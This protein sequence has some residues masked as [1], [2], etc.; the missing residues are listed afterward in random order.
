M[1]INIVRQKQEYT[2]SPEAL[3]QAQRIGI[4]GNRAARLKRMARR[5]APFTS[6]QGNRRF[7]DFVLAIAPDKKV[8][9]ISRL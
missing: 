2:V 5:A 4:Y 9:G 3:A 6:Q 1:A 7:E 8:V